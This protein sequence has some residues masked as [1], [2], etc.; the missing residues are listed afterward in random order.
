[1]FDAIQAWD[2]SAIEWMCENRVPVLTPFFSL[3]THLGDKG[4]FWIALALI[5]FAI[6]KTRKMGLTMGI[7]MGIGIIIG[8]GILKNVVARMRPYDYYDLI[9]GTKDYIDTIVAKPDDFSFPSGHTQASFAAAV[10]MFLNNKRVGVAAIILAFLIAISR[11]YL[12]VHFPTDII[13]GGLMGTAWAFIA[14]WAVVKY[15]KR[16]EERENNIFY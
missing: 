3:I 10:A 2:F 12:C 4:L 13:C 14:N 6:P 7:A 11:F 5:L 9:H 1:M 8:N 16:K 15:Y